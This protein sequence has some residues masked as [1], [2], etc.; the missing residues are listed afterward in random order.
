M[1]MVYNAD[2]TDYIIHLFLKTES[3]DTE[4]Y[5]KVDTWGSSLMTLLY[6]IDQH[7]IVSH[8]LSIYLS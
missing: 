7:Q 4:L 6:N 8:I 5:R 2:N 3:T 1:S